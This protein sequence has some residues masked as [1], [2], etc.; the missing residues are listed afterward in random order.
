MPEPAQ[1]VPRFGALGYDVAQRLLFRGN[2]VVPLQPKAL[3]LLQLLLQRRGE[4]I[5]K[6]MS[7]LAVPFSS[8][9]RRRLAGQAAR[10]RP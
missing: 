5:S 3:D 10:L 9:N 2:G 8:Q 7:A 4:A 1:A 6:S